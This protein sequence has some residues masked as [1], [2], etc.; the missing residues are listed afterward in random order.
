MHIKT[1]KQC[2]RS[3]AHLD[4]HGMDAT[5]RGVNEGHN[6]RPEGLRQKWVLD[7]VEDDAG[8]KG[9]E[10]VPPRR[11]GVSLGWGQ[12]KEK[13]YVGGNKN[14]DMR[15]WPG[16]RGMLTQLLFGQHSVRIDSKG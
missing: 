4:A 8:G 14:K 2:M 7:A 13:Q 6:R 3:C 16:R 9:P 10:V 1:T 11:R 12:Q 5:E 15:V